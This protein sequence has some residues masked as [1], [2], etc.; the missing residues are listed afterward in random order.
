[1]IQYASLKV[2]YSAITADSGNRHI[3]IKSAELIIR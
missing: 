2:L 3:D 1:M